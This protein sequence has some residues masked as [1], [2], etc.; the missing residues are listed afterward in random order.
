MIHLKKYENYEHGTSDHDN[1]I[2][3]EGL[4]ISEKPKSMLISENLY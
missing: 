1:D 4:E 2:L 3:L